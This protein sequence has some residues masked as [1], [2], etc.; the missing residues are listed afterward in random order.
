GCFRSRIET[1]RRSIASVTLKRSI[2][3]NQTK[4]EQLSYSLVAAV[5]LFEAKTPVARAWLD[6]PRVEA[7]ERLATSTLKRGEQLLLKGNLDAADAEFREAATLEPTNLDAQ[8]GLVR[9]AR[10]RLDYPEAL[11]L[12][13][14]AATDHPNSAEV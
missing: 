1:I 8:L 13:D 9:V 7:R 3:R 14:K 12:L 6:T 5:L 4:P 10:T 2:N 11:N